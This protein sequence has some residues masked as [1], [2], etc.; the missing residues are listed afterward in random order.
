MSEL[1][2]SEIRD[3]PD[4]AP[5]VPDFVETDESRSM[6][7]K[8]VW[9]L[10]IPGSVIAYLL[11]SFPYTAGYLYVRVPMGYTLAKRWS[12]PDWEHCFIVPFAIAFMLYEKRADLAAL[13][14]RPSVW[15]GGMVAL[16]G[17]LFYWAGYRVNNLYFGFISIQILLAAL[18]ILQL[19]WRFMAAL[20]FPW[21]FLGFMW[22]LIFLESYLALPLRIVMSEAG[23]NALNLIGIPTVKS[24]TG[25]LSAPDLITGQAVGERFSVDVA[26][27][28]SGIKSLFALMMV[29]AL[30]GFFT[31]K[32]WWKQAILFAFSIP[33]AV[34]GNLIRILMLTIG[35]LMFGAEFAI[36]DGLEDPSTFHMVAGFFVFAVAL[37]GMVLVATLLNTDYAG[38]WSKWKTTLATARLPEEKNSIPGGSSKNREDIY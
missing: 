21:L 16:L 17:F 27:P 2:A 26:N 34:A 33:L 18:I 12:E 10:W 36:G 7:L 30:Y 38:L 9:S 3:V 1:V 24:G 13:K 14:V 22:P 35:T 4:E 31:M 23:V 25:I 6:A 8:W 19:G 37:G 29:S 11:A 20:A 15:W 28:C 32:L 5:S